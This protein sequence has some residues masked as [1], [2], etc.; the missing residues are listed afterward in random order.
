MK[1]PKIM[2]ALDHISKRTA[3]AIQC[4]QEV[5]SITNNSFLARGGAIESIPGS[6]T[7]S[8]LAA[9]GNYISHLLF[10][11]DSCSTPE[12]SPPA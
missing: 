12:A 7:S 1:N 6:S 10:S 11:T 9:K 5:A 8:S 3:D 4:K 2:T